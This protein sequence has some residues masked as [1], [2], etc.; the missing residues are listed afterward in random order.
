MIR[1]KNGVVQELGEM[2]ASY[3]CNK[4]IVYLC[5]NDAGCRIVQCR[6]PAHHSFIV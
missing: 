6:L 3:Q 5:L 4:F 2:R 1:E